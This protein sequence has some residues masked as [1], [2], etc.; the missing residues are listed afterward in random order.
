MQLIVAEKMTVG[1][2]D[3]LSRLELK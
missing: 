1:R 2:R 3:Y